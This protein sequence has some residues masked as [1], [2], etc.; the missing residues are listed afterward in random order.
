MSAYVQSVRLYVGGGF[1]FGN[2]Q[3]VMIYNISSGEWATLPPYR[4]QLFCNGSNQVLIGG[5]KCIVSDGSRVLGVWE[6]DHKVWTHPYPELSTQRK[7]CS[8]VTYN[9]WLVVAGSYP[10]LHAF[11]IEVLNTESKRWYAGPTTPI[12]WSSMKRAVVGDMGYF[13][14]GYAGI[15]GLPTKNVY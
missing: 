2:K 6:A 8:V 3:T 12:P 1:A 4:T 10:Y 11:P 15:G 7:K 9:Q 5:E 13:M 14:G